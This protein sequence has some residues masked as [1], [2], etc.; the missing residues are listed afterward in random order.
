M[1]H[2]IDDQ[3]V[4]EDKSVALQHVR[5]FLRNKLKLEN[6]DDIKIIDCHR[7]P[8][9]PVDG[10]K[11]RNRTL[12]VKKTPR[13]II[14]KVENDFDCKNI[15]SK[16]SLENLKA[17]NEI[18]AANKEPKLAISRH[19]PDELRQERQALVPALTAARN[20]NQKGSIRFD[21]T[22][23][24]MYLHVDNVQEQSAD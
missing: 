18:A 4:W 24:K 19:L 20:K 10:K 5:D 21:W 23:L 22:D 14:F 7:L 8:Q 1:I 2:G 16:T 11:L 9:N 6:A 3:H 12:S 17:E 15:W 13:P